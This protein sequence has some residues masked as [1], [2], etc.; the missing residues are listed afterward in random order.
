[1]IRFA[2]FSDVPAIEACARE[3]YAKYVER[4]GKEPAPMVADFASLVENR[5]VRL[6]TDMN[7]GLEGF[8]IFYPE[9]NHM[10]L[11]NVAVANKHRGKG[12][13]RRLIALCEAEAVRL[14]Y[15]SVE[16][17][18]NEKMTENL[19]LYPLL[20]YVEF[21]RRTEDGFNRIY[22]RKVLR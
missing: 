11:E 6:S 13:G 1:M 14:G 10:H 4:I 8:V 3:A 19:A 17:Y 15:D 9:G 2:N 20:G 21:D 18:T 16:L 5:H 12:I 7:D 22:F